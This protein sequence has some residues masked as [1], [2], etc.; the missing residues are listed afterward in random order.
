MA[1]ICR[2]KSIWKIQSTICY[3]TVLVY[4][5]VDKDGTTKEK[6]FYFHIIIPGHNFVLDLYEKNRKGKHK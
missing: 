1:F 5:Y 3:H 4:T 2:L 6:T